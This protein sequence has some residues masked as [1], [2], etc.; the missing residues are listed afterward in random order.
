M[1][2]FLILAAVALLPVTADAN[3]L[4]RIAGDVDIAVP[5]DWRLATDTAAFPVQLIHRSDS[6]EVLMFR[7]DIAEGD[8]IQDEHDLKKSVDLVIN[9][10]INNLPEGLLR[11]STGFYDKYRTGFTLEFASVDSLSGIALEHS[12]RG[13][14]YR[15]PGD[16]Q[17]MF[18]VWGKAAAA[19]WPQVKEA[20]ERIQ[21]EFAYRGEYESEVFAGKSMSYWPLLLLVVGLIGLFLLRPGRRKSKEAA[22]AQTPE[23]PA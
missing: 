15:L 18:T 16:R 7:S 5:T 9:E 6:A 4:V 10:V 3:Q 8:L 13:I 12:I 1:I 20:V 19:K 11:V 22:T 14:I 21:D 2:R 23:K 17:V